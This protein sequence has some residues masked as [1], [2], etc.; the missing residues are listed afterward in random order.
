MTS[1]CDIAKSYLKSWFI[2]DFLAV[3]PRF[4]RLYDTEEENWTDI[5][6]FTKIARIGRLIRLLRILKLAKTLKQKDMM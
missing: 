2:I 5:L 3:V 1:R 4:L 6:R